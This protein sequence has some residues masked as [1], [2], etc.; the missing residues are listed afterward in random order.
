MP[1]S[2]EQLKCSIPVRSGVA[3]SIK[4]VLEREARSAPRAFREKKDRLRTRCSLAVDRGEVR[5]CLSFSR[6]DGV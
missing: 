2:D 3:I 5:F 4:E 1:F 6:P